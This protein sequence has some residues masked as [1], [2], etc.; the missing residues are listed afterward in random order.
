MALVKVGVCMEKTARNYDNKEQRFSIKGT[1][2]WL[3]LL[4][5]QHNTQP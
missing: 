1:F 4:L 5:D 2:S 3:L